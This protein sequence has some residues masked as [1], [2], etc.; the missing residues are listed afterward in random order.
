MAW[1][2]CHSRVNRDFDVKCIFQGIG[3]NPR[4]LREFVGIEKELILSVRGRALRISA[5]S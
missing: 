2:M 1:N 3:I 4:M 5:P